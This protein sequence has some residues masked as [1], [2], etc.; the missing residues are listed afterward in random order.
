MSVASVT[1]L[2]EKTIRITVHVDDALAMIREAERDIARYAKNVITIYEKMPEFQFVYFCFYAYDSAALFEHMLG[3]DPKQYL[4]FSLDA[5]DGFFFT[6][7]GGMAALYE[8]AKAAL[9]PVA[10]D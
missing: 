2:D 4:S 5:P 7:Y 1:V 9:L 10:A 3:V 6:L 8:Q